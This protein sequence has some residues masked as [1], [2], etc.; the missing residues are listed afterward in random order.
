MIHDGFLKKNRLTKTVVYSASSGT[1]VAPFTGFVLIRA[2]GPGGGGGRN[3][4]G[5]GAYCEKVQA[6]TV[7]DNFPW[8]VGAGDSGTATTVTGPASLS[9]SAGAAVG[10][11]GGTATGGDT[12][13]NGPNG[14]ASSGNSGGQGATAPNGVVQGPAILGGAGGGGG[15]KSDNGN[16]GFPPGGGGGGYGKSGSDDGAGAPGKVVFIFYV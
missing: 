8:V 5:S 7:S 16:P 4:G 6:C 2:W 11:T 9:L 15:G 12:N 10:Q 13:T 1:E 14:G 3:G